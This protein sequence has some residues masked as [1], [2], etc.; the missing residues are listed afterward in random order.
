[1]NQIT[2]TSAAFANASSIPPQYTCDGA[3]VSPPLSIAGVP[4]EARSLALIVDDPDAPGGT[5]VHWLLW[6][7]DPKPSA[8]GEASVPSGATQGRNDFGRNTY[9]GPC[10]PSGTHRYFFKVYALD[11]MLDLKAGSG[12]ADLERAMQGHV[13]SEGAILGLYKRR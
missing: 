11:R 7:V 9:G 1:M 12:K 2:I 3:D 6:N 8:I 4:R 5:W 13:L 10:P